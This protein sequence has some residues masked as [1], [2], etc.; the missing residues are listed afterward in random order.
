MVGITVAIVVSIGSA[1]GVLAALARR[2][3]PEDGWRELLRSGMQ[4]ARAKE[5]TFVDHHRHPDTPPGGVGDL[6]TV[7]QPV[8]WPAYTEVPQLRAALSRLKRWGRR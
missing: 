4:S 8:E 6:F 1:A 3:A 2:H 5:M 7:G